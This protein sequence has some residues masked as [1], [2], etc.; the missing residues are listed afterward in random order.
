[1][2]IFKFGAAGRIRIKGEEFAPPEWKRSIWDK[3]KNNDLF[4]PIN[5]HDEN[6]IR[7]VKI[8]FNKKVFIVGINIFLLSFLYS[9]CKDTYVIL[10]ARNNLVK[11]NTI[12]FENQL[13]KQLKLENKILIDKFSNTRNDKFKIQLDTNINNSLIFT[14]YLKEKFWETNL[15]TLKS[16]IL[17]L[18]N[19]LLI[20]LMISKYYWKRKKS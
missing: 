17:P 18:A 4:T 15:Q 8:F 12:N 5:I 16:T 7:E 13:P 11:I 14:N 19:D 2:K 6:N 1:M 3:L 9:F 10:Q 20:L